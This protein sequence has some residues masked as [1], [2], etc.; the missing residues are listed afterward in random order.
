MFPQTKPNQTKPNQTKP[1]QTKPNQTKPNQTLK[2]ME[3]PPTAIKSGHHFMLLHLA[4]TAQP[5]WNI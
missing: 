1:N 4:E 3:L 5:T 2:Q